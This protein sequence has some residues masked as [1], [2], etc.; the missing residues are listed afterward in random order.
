MAKPGI[1]YLPMLHEAY[2]L[3]AWQVWSFLRSQPRHDEPVESPAPPPVE[4]A[5]FEW[6]PEPATHN[7]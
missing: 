3:G 2:L 5:P 4:E 7:A 6:G 1:H